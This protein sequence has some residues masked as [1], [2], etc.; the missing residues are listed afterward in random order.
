MEDAII[1][2]E[3]PGGTH[4]TEETVCQ[5]TGCS[6]SP[7]RE[8]LRLLEK[9]GLAV[10]VPRRGF[11]ISELS[12]E[13]LDDLYVCRISLE[14]TAAKLAA[15][16]GTD[17]ELE[18]IRQAHLACAR[19]LEQD[20]L[21][22]HFKANVE[23]SECIFAASHNRSLSRLLN[24]IHKQ[25]LRYRYAAYEQSRTIRVKS[26]ENNAKF[27]ELITARDAKAA[28]KQAR[29]SIETTHS[30]IRNCLLSAV[31]EADTTG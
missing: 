8:A 15:E 18:A 5:M 25:S 27:V 11:R 4:L 13:E 31:N 19:K 2:G 1:Y 14:M 22:G 9:D 16:K 6:R 17:A 10:R 20:D 29:K 21:R 12:V 30:V 3:I 23:M 24:S 28:A 26:V 7:V